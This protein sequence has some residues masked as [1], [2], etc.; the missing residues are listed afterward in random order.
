MVLSLDGD[1]DLD[2]YKVADQAVLEAFTPD[3]INSRQ[4]IYIPSNVQ[5][6]IES[7]ITKAIPGVNPFDP[8]T[9]VGGVD[10]LLTPDNDL[11][12][13]PTGDTPFAIG[14][15]NI[16][17]SVRIACSVYQGTLPLHPDFGLPI[18]VGMNTADLDAKQTLAAVR[19]MLANDPSF[20]RVD[21]A[22]VIKNGPTASI[23]VGVVAAGTEHTIPIEYNVI[24]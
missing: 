9:F 23:S 21:F 11:V 13:T 1:P 6:D 19:K 20:V 22:K 18:K 15:T 10:L 5:S 24:R 3:T 12:I 16:I 7:F 4:L 14:L 2:I 17:Q 8:L